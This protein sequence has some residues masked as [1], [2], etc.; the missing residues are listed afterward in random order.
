VGVLRR[1]IEEKRAQE[2]KAERER[3]RR[4]TET[5]RRARTLWTGSRYREC[6]EVLQEAQKE[7][8]AETEI[9]KLLETARHDEGEQEKA[10]RHK[11]EQLGE[12]R[13]LIG[14]RQYEGALGILDQLLQQWPT[15]A[16][17]KELRGVAQQGRQ[18]QIRE[19]QLRED[20]ASLKKMVDEGRYPEAIAKAEKLRQDFP[21]ENE[22]GKLVEAARNAQILFER[23]RR[24]EQLIEQ[25]NQEIQ[26]DRFREAILAAETALREF[27]GNTE[28]AALME[29]A[30]TQLAEK[31]KRELRD[32]RVME[33]KVLIGR[34]DLTGALDLVRQTVEAVGPDREIR[35]LQL[36]VEVEHEQLEKKKRRQQ[37]LLDEARGLLH[38]GKLGDAGKV[39]QQ[40]VEGSLLSETDTR[41]G[42]LRREI[43]EKRAQEEKAE[44]ERQRR[45]TE[46]LRRARTLW[47]GS[48][49]RE[50]I[51]VL[52]EAQK[53]F[54]AE[55]EIVKLLEVARHDEGEQ[56]K[57]ER[58]KQ[59]Q[60]GEAR[61]LIGA[62][63]YEGALGILDQLLQQWPTD[64]AAKELRGA[65][66]QG[67][68]EQIR[69]QQ[70]REDLASLKKMVDEG[71]YPEAIAKAEKLRQ[72][73]PRENEIGKL[74]DTARN[75]QD[76]LERK[77]RQEQQVAQVNQEIQKRALPG[78]DCGG[79]GC[80]HRVSGEHRVGGLDG[81]RQD[82]VGGKK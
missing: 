70:L 67:R 4:L 1:E 11:Q 42:V 28:L 45:L 51:E 78:S 18:E 13:K 47:T 68:Q 15:D 5:L 75:A 32:K 12:A 69:E 60:L 40:A 31:E 53:E 82:A 80:S 39:L 22:I 2:E 17:A 36:Q 27:P 57:A 30:K 20:L 49:Y 23:T 79:R 48:R 44:R 74:V 33:I 29:S 46:T 62:R 38:Q 34:G 55:T 10:E 76:Q 7:F 52:Q 3:Q 63:Q 14:A 26:N 24:Q 16:A 54:P 41:V 37:E 66:Q 71:R 58:H 77:R 65:A 19:Q 25:V 21:R 61:K 9:V 50:C 35:Q 73:F 6:I 59:E 43:E 64:A 8:P 56:E 72:N 81:E